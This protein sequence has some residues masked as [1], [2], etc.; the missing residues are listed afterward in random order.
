MGKLYK[1]DIKNRFTGA[2]YEIT[3][4]GDGPRTV[5][6]KVLYDVISNNEQILSIIDDTQEKV[7][8][9]DVGFLD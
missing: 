5:H 2:T 8:D 6:K 9:N 4:F 1:L 3:A 7:F